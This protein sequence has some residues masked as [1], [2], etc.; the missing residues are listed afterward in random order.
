MAQLGFGVI[1]TKIGVMG[2]ISRRVSFASFI[3]KILLLGS[4]ILVNFVGSYSVLGA[5]KPSNDVREGLSTSIILAS[6]QDIQGFPWIDRLEGFTKVDRFEFTVYQPEPNTLDLFFDAQVTTHAEEGHGAPNQTYFWETWWFIG[7][8]ALILAATVIVGYRWRFHF[9]EQHRQSLAVEVF[10]RTEEIERRRQMAS[11]LSDIVRLLNTNQPLEKSL[12][13]I[14]QQAVGLTEASK[15]AIFE[16]QND[17]VVVQACYPPGETYLL[18]LNDPNSVSARCLLE[19]T[20]LNRLLIFSRIDPATMKSDTRWELVRGDYR[21]ALCTPLVVDEVVY[22]GLVLYYGEERAFTPDEVR[23]AHTLADQASLAITNAQLKIKAQEAAVAAERTRLARELHDAVTQTLFSANLIA[24]V[25]PKLWEND[26][27]QAHHRLEELQ[28]LTR[29][30]L[31]EMR[32]L[33]M[34]LRPSALHEADLLELFRHL[35]DA[36]TGRTGVPVKVDLDVPGKC[37]MPL[38]VKL[39][40]YRIAQE[41]LSNILKHADASQ[42]WFSFICDA[43][44]VVLT[45]QDDGQGF[46]LGHVPGGHLG[47]KIMKERAEA[48]GAELNFS[49]RISAGTILHLVWHFRENTLK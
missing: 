13:F 18:D 20:F 30:A 10:E 5:D 37:E 49:S 35:T 11:G 3:I 40:F 31:G 38:N 42:V 23:F 25:L 2:H 4:F 33:L 27:Q 15:A 48:V 29:G 17:L 6:F 46:D 28:Q 9:I 32:T 21:T 14:V 1:S 47:I 26:P 19:S 24:D 41:G 12:D 39:V 43:K 16:R 34:E 7:L 8:V 44:Q 45:L 22:G 36:F